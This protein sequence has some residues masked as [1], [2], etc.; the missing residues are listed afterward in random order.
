MEKKRGDGGGVEGE[1]IANCQ[2]F[3]NHEELLR[4]KKDI[5]KGVATIL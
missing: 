5:Q 4:A 3:V 2:I 1:D